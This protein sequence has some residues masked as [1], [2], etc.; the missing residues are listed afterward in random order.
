MVAR[1]AAVH[2]DHGFYGLT[3]RALRQDPNAALIALLQATMTAVLAVLPERAAERVIAAAGRSR[4]SSLPV[5]GST[6]QSIVRGRPSE[7]DYL[8]GEI[9]RLGRRLGLPTPCN[10]HVVDVVHA[11]ERSHNFRRVEE[12]LPP[13]ASVRADTAPVG[14][15]GG[16]GEQRHG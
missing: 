13:G 1:A 2:P 6:W 16:P 12:L 15:A 5:R 4:L 10:G 14:G 11:V 7:V 9:V 3:P 8:N